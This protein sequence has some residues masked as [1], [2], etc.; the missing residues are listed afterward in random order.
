MPTITTNFNLIKPIQGEFYNVDVPN[1]NMDTIDGVL[2]TLQDAIS[3]GAS[4]QDLDLLRD[5]LVTH[6]TNDTNHVKYAADTGTA[7]AKV[8]TINPAPTSYLEGT[9][10]SFKNATQNTGAATININGLGAKP[11][12]KSNGNPLTS[13]ALKANSI[14]T[15]RYNG[16]SF[17]LQGEGGEYG[18]ATVNDVLAGKTIGTE[19][20]LKTGTI[21]YYAG[22]G[23]ESSNI[24]FPPGYSDT[25]L[26]IF[27]P[28]TGYV[29]PS[30]FLEIAD[31]DFKAHN[32]R[33]GTNIFGVLGTLDIAALGGARYASGR[34]NVTQSYGA[35]QYAG[36]TTQA[37][38]YSVSVSLN[39]EPDFVYMRGP[40]SVGGNTFQIIYSKLV[41]ELFNPTVHV[42]SSAS[43]RDAVQQMQGMNPNALSAY[44]NSTGFRFPSLAGNSVNTTYEWVAIKF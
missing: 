16:T 3:S 9:A 1:N 41:G 31:P 34:V 14:Y 11:I 13:G 40:Y 22:L 8:V 32:I 38:Y 17:I 39:F 7:N 20:G 36:S 19:E 5:A 30:S 26:D 2:K 43:I 37:S 35:F 23:F 18:T 21:P 25:V 12:L 29:T 27:Q 33:A 24:R 15:V 28:N 6:L 42:G 4:E 10:V 44:I